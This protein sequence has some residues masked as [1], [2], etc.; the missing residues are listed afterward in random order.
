[1]KIEIGLKR[2]LFLFLVSLSVSLN[3]QVVKSNTVGMHNGKKC[4]IHIVQPGQT[5][6][7]ITKLYGAKE[8]EAILK[9]DIHHLAV[10]DTVWIPC[11]D[12][13]VTEKTSTPQQ[14]D[15]KEYQFVKVEQGQTLYSLSRTYN[16]SIEDLNELN[17]ELRVTGLKAGQMIKVPGVAK[18][19]GQ[20]AGGSSQQ[21][22][23]GQQASSQQAA[24]PAGRQP[25]TYTPKAPA[26]P[27]VVSPL[28]EP[29]RVHVSLLMPLHLG[30]LDKISTTKF[31]IDQRG[32]KSYGAFEYIQFYEGL[33]IGMERL[34]RMGCKVVL[35]VVDV[36]GKSKQD[37]LTSINTHNVT[38]SDFII[39]LLPK[40]QFEY[41]AE[42]AQENRLFIINPMSERDE[43][44]EG[45]PYVFKCMSSVEG[46]VDEL[47]KV[48][49]LMP[50]KPHLYVITSGSRNEAR[51]RGIVEEKLKARG[52]VPYT[53]FDWSANSKLVAA[54]KKTPGCVVLNIY[55]Q[56]RDKNHIQVSTLLNR[57]AAAKGS[58]VTLVSLENYINKYA[59][60]DF[61]QL[62]QA[63]YMT[64]NTELD[65]NDPSKKDFIDAFN[66]RY[67]VDPI[68]TYATSANDII[69]HF[70]YGLKTRGTEFWRSPNQTSM[71]GVLYPMF[72]SQS[73]KG[74][75]FVNESAVFYKLN[76]F[77]FMPL[78][79]R[80]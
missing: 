70:V 4:Y 37:V 34:E 9:S 26:E 31:D 12:C 52:N 76:N 41:A 53:F 50:G 22:S 33:L 62:Q 74:H 58:N 1:M 49:A 71:P 79:G 3:A 64:V 45:N 6:Y 30:D 80:Y 8:H 17:P 68:G 2:L 10:D 48:V 63:N 72:F 7:S 27:A 54:L 28:V 18:A 55:D 35:N 24:K 78:S 42:W 40:E 46:E 36:S 75:G 65:Y 56:N 67:K 5:V 32:K 73:D 51:V 77:R 16:V 20:Q 60:M 25:A 39:A 61:A 23:G 59:D 44:V 69:I 13:V 66:E 14:Q 38:H 15:K 19:G 47:L 11:T 43:I 29:G 57:L 21:A